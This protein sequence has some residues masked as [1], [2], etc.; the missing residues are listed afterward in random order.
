MM[1]WIIRDVRLRGTNDLIDLAIRDGL[2]A[3][4]GP[5]LPGPAVREIE[6]QGRLVAPTFVE[7]HYHLDKCFLAEETPALTVLADYLLLEAERKRTYTAPDVA[8]RAGRAV[9]QLLANGVTTMRSQVDIDP[10]CGLTALEG[11]LATQRRYAGVMDIQLVAFPQLGICDH[12]DMPALLREAMHMGCVAIGGHPQLEM[13][14]AEAQRHIEIVFEIAREFD[15]NVDLHVDETDDPNTHYI[16]DVAVK[17]IQRGWQG[18]VNVGHVCSLALMNDYY[19][20]EIIRLI[21]RAGIT[22]TTNPT[23]NVMFR[24]VLDKDPKWRGL[25][26]VRQLAAAGV[27]VCFGQETIKSVFITTWRNPDPLITAQ[28][29]GYVAQY[30]RLADMEALFD[31]AT[32]N[33]ARA[34]R[35]EDYGLAVGREASFN[36]FEAEDVVEA[37]RFAAPRRYVFKRGQLVVEHTVERTWHLPEAVT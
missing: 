19:A 34:L 37:L 31:M 8:A 6:A 11:V 24:A 29:L 2:F 10:V 14:N 21:K 15:A 9:E 5:H 1:D 16:Q 36:V 3:A 26:R 20:A 35:L 33:A 23:S 7:P 12:R 27:N 17:T 32:C 4:I 13:A 22:V 25:T 18:R 28:L 30:H